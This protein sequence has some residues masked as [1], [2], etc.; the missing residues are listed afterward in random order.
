MVPSSFDNYFIAMAGA[1][2][3]L[4]G[5]LF[6][7]VSI[8]PERTFGRRAHTQR[9]AVAA[10]A[11]SAMVNAF[12]I[13]AASLIPGQ[14][15]LG[16]ITLT[17]ALVGILSALSLAMQALHLLRQHGSHW[18]TFAR[19]LFM[20]AASLVIYGLE[21]ANAATLIRDPSDTGAVFS[22]ATL[23][24]AVYGVGLIRAWELLGAPRTGISGWLNPLR[25]LPDDDEETGV[26]SGGPAAISLGAPPP[27]HPAGQASTQAG[28]VRPR[29]S[30]PTD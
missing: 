28:N 6:V 22:L 17:L 25:D 30:G 13:S 14:D 23:V 18:T 1:G 9:Q 24:L 15:V 7:A 19:V 29:R 4:I 21:I 16:P 20:I 10:N 8:N 3:A 26:A 5:L 12:F 27:A 11:F 2:G